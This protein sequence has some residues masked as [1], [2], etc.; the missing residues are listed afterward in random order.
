M[1]SLR[2][3]YLDTYTCGLLLFSAKIIT[4]F[5][6]PSTAV[7]FEWCAQGWPGEELFRPNG[8]DVPACRLDALGERLLGLE[9]WPE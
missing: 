3:I 8:R 9:S 1:R 2:E 4:V 7:H 5:C 6:G